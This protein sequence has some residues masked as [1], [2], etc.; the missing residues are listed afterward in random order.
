MAA[1]LRNHYWQFRETH[2]RNLEYETGKDLAEGILS[3]FQWC[4]TNP[5]YKNEQLKTPIRKK[6]KDTGEETITTIVHIPTARPYTISGLCVH[7]GIDFK[8]WKAYGQREGFIH[9]V[10][11][12]EEIIETQQLEGAAVG[13]FNANIIARKL[14]L[15][16]KSE[17]TGKDG[18]PIETKFD[19]TLNLNK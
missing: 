8:T 7:L 18:G 19:I 10:T 9:I 16:D 1:P 15:A 6:D 12:A 14:G 5:W 4:D 11:H 13:A 17:H 2:G 3:Y